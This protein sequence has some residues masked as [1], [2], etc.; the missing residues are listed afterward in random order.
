MSPW[1]FAEKLNKDTFR[2][3]QGLAGI[4][5]FISSYGDMLFHT[6]LYTARLTLSSFL[7]RQV[8]QDIPKWRR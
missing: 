3:P 4:C 2:P 1:V 7:T 5:I 8:G 6:T